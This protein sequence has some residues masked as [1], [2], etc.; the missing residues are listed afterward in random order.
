MAF[1]LSVVSACRVL[2]RRNDIIFF[3]SLT[4]I[5]VRDR[6]TPGG[7]VRPKGFDKLIKFKYLIGSRTR[8]I[9]ACIFMPQ[10]LCY[11]MLNE[12]LSLIVCLIHGNIYTSRSSRTPHFHNKTPWPLVRERTMPTERPPFVDEI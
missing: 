5:S 4:L 12:N 8:D 1:G 3:L 11:H 6:V 10:A 2:L 7:L 9:P